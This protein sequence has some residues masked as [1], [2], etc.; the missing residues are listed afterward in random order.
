MD[1]LYSLEKRLEAISDE[2]QDFKVIEGFEIVDSRSFIEG[3]SEYKL[4]NKLPLDEFQKMALES[5]F[6]LEKGEMLLVVGPPG[7]GKTQFIIEA[8]RILGKTRKTLVVSQIHQAVDNVFER[9]ADFEEE[10]NE[11]IDYA[12][13]VGHISKVSEHAKKFSPENRHLDDISEDLPF[14]DL[15]EAY[16]SAFKNINREYESVLEKRNFLVGST[17]LKTVTH[18]L[19]K[20]K[21][22]YVF[23]DESHN[24]CLSTALLVLRRAEKAVLTGDPWQI[25]PIY[26]SVISISERPKFG[27]FNILYE[28][29]EKEIKEILW[30][31][32]NY[33]SNPKIT[34]FSSEFIYGGKVIPNPKE[35]YE[36]NLEKVTYKWMNPNEPMVFIHVDGMMI[37]NSNEDE[38]KVVAWLIKEFKKV[39]IDSENVV[40]LTPYRNQVEKI[41]EEMIKRDL[42]RN[43]VEIKTVHSYLGAEKDIVIF[44]LVATYPLS[45]N[46]LDRRMINVAT[47]RA[48]KKLIVVGNYN[49][50]IENPDKPAFELL[51]YIMKNG[52]LVAE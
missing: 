16:S 8:G 49:K 37:D 40:V 52:L 34:K 20:Q 41:R 26:S 11:N 15:V 12:I 19:S 10:Y 2:M 7:T 14:D 21:F 47:T 5:S 29:A 18:P 28:L 48:K 9:L 39:G 1:F 22:N 32:Y 13:R 35:N 43:E 46:F 31:R 27:I 30:L 3:V 17:A 25:P 42:R 44:S 23:M 24:I 36:L 6:Q 51:D 50:V 38:A 33:R 4:E 45:F